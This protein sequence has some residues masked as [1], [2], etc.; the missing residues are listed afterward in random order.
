MMLLKSLLI[1]LL[2][3]IINVSSEVDA[4]YLNKIPDIE[5]EILKTEADLEV[6]NVAL[7][8]IS[9][10]DISDESESSNSNL[11]LNELKSSQLKQLQ[12]VALN[13]IELY[14]NLENSK[15]LTDL[16]IML[17]R[18][19]EQ[20]IKS[21]QQ[22][23][24]NAKEDLQLVLENEVK[25]KKEKEKIES[26]IKKLTDSIIDEAS[27]NNLDGEGVSEKKLNSAENIIKGIVEGVSD[28]ADIL[29]FNQ[30][31]KDFFVEG[32]KIKGSSIETVVKVQDLDD[33]EDESDSLTNS[34]D[35][36]NNNGSVSNNQE[37]NS[38]FSKNFNGNLFSKLKSYGNSHESS[39][40][41]VLIDIENNQYSLSKS[42][43][44]SKYYE[45]TI[46]LQDIFTVILTCFAF[47]YI[48]SLL[49]CPIF[50]GYILS[51]IVLGQLN[52]IT[53][54]IQ[55]E[56]ISRGLGVLFIMFFLGLEFNFSKILKVWKISLFGSFLIYFFIMVVVYYIGCYFQNETK[57]ALVVGSSIF[58]SSTAVGL[59]CLGTEDSET[60]YGRSI[61][62][63]LVF[64]D[65][66][67]GILI[68]M[69]PILEKSGKEILSSLISLFGSL[70]LFFF[71]VAGVLKYPIRFLINSL[72][73]K[74]N[75]ELLLLGS[76]SVCIFVV[77]ISSKLGIG[78]EL[79]CFVA[80]VMIS[81]KQHNGKNLLKT[82]E[83]VKDLFSSLFFASIGL[84]IYP[85]FLFNEIMLLLT[86]TS[87]IILLK[88]IVIF[89]LFF[90]IFKF[91]F[92]NCVSIAI[93][94][95]QISEFVFVFSSRA[96]KAGVISREVY[97]LLLGVTA[98][99]LVI[100][101][102]LWAIFGMQEKTNFKKV[103]EFED[104]FY[105]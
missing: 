21:F 95:S 65:I 62:G 79:A 46:L 97:Y 24:L 3:A 20:I 43:D 63:I 55:V 33:A 99:S 51:G 85:S 83:P 91:H 73:M 48:F 50:F 44:I 32:Q 64:Q 8:E 68:T 78:P 36:T 86:L 29:E 100:S 4:S 66:V 17:K 82:I 6:K 105:V 56:T 74:V 81:P 101:P 2:I 19:S 94:L 38:N 61:I 41:P 15:N 69:L 102:L 26:R 52:L 71:I 22:T 34:N 75:K 88:F 11:E 72:R 16:E 98:L 14:K 47:S 27:S 96:K 80:G 67:L 35:E 103:E 37:V 39:K 25:F 31:G 93:G 9:Q 59:K 23:V 60:V 76:I 7:T 13:V 10:K 49:N 12:S 57:E 87:L 18:N 89:T 58:L 54:L 40:M 28:Q 70:I 53:S 42:S 5:N 104:D 84:H 90:V 1:I 92:K 77:Q 30:K 45:D